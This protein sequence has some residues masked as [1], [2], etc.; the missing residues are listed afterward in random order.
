MAKGVLVDIPKCIGCE[1]C[2]VACK[3]WNE[4]DWDAQEK[5]KP[6]TD[7][8]KE[9]N[10]GLWPNEWTSINRYDL[11]KSGSPAGRFVKTQCFHCE[12]PSCASACFSKAFQN[13]PQ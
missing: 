5:A 2:S 10:K 4:L 9:P 8:A 3:L 11:D 7:R 12:E 6:A 13:L 1:S